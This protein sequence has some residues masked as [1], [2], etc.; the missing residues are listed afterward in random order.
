MQGWEDGADENRNGLRCTR[1]N[2]CPTQESACQ[3]S[4]SSDPH[5]ESASCL[6]AIG[7]ENCRSAAVNHDPIC[8]LLLNTSS[9]SAAEPHQLNCS[10]RTRQTI[11]FIE[12]SIEAGNLLDQDKLTHHAGDRHP[13]SSSND[14][15]NVRSVKPELPTPH[16]GQCT[17][18]H[19]RAQTAAQAIS[20]WCN[21][22]PLAQHFA[23]AVDTL[24]PTPAINYK[25]M[26]KKKNGNPYS[27]YISYF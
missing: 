15:Y 21:S 3:A 18:P 4:R 20:T 19:R 7:S 17:A 13:L 25:Y 14:G 8:N 2:P 23:S 11:S 22:S 10:T 6:T 24:Q 9:T 16:V 26:A 5:K 27:H 12:L 1:V